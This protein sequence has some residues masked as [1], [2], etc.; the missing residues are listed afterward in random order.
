MKIDVVVVWVATFVYALKMET[1]LS[2]ETLVSYHITTC[3][4]NTQDRELN[5][6][7]DY[8]SSSILKAKDKFGMKLFKLCT[9]GGYTYEFSIYFGK[10]CDP[11]R[12]TLTKIVLFLMKSLL[13]E[14][15]CAS[16]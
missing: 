15:N 16:T 5:V 10:E 13:D 2:S 12:S 8:P 6:E 3:C 9:D 14:G 11:M 4:Y 1:A 7:K